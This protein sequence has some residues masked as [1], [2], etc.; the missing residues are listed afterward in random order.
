MGEGW[1]EREERMALRMEAL[2]ASFPSLRGAPG[3]DPWNA[4]ALNLWACQGVSHGERCAARFVL[5]VWNQHEAWEC[6][7]FEIM[8]ALQVWDAGH[9]AAFVA[10]ARA[11]WWA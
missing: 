2:A 1:D 11:P 8:E 4:C 10:W 5:T 7:H 3:A 9:T 6:G